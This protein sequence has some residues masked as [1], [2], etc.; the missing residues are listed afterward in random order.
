MDSINNK[1]KF[2]LQQFIEYKNYLEE[3]IKLHKK[4]N[5]KK[6]DRDKKIVD[7]KTWQSKSNYLDF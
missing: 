6:K 3:K 5:K 4:K 2:S 1:K 7:L